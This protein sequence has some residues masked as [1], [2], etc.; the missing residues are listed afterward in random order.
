MHCGP[1]EADFCPK[2]DCISEDLGVYIKDDTLST[3][4]AVQVKSDST[5]RK[6]GM[7]RVA[8]DGSVREVV[9]GR[10]VMNGQDRLATRLASYAGYLW[11]AVDWPPGRDKARGIVD[12]HWAYVGGGE[13]RSSGGRTLGG[14]MM[15]APVVACS[16]FAPSVRRVWCGRISGGMFRDLPARGGTIGTYAN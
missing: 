5:Y 10:E 1:F 11:V 13:R 3:S 6:E 12:M 4:S 7:T 9:T 8:E 15:I 2:Y 14:W 16:L